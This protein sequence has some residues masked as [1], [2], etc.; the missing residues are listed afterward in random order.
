MGNRA[1]KFC[2]GRIEL[3]VNYAVGGVYL[4]DRYEDRLEGNVLFRGGGG[5]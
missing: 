4:R 2:F 3:G 1:G 5:E